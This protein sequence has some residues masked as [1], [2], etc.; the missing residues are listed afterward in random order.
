MD[1][2][3]KM[4]E[5]MMGKMSSKEKMEMMEKMMEKFFESMAEDEKKQMMRTMMPKMMEQMTGGKGMMGMMGMMMGKQ[6]DEEGGT[7]FNPMDMCQKMMSSVNQSREVAAFATPEIRDLFFEW[8]Q[9][10]EEEIFQAV[11]KNPSISIEQIA[12]K[13]HLSSQSVIYFLGKLAQENKISLNP[14]E[15]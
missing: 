3:E 8:A 15:K 13:V 2:K 1:L 14:K 10:V 9:Q 6:D 5:S 12:E 7:G 11:Q 4:M